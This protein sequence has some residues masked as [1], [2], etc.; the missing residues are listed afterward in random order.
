M[1]YDNTSFYGD[2]ITDEYD[3]HN[4]F[5]NP[6]SSTGFYVYHILGDSFDKMSDMCSQFLNDFSILSADTRGLD[7]F[8]GV[9]YNLERPTLPSGR[10]LND[11]EYRIYLYLRNC[12]LITMQDIEVNFSKCFKLDD[13]DVYFTEESDFLAT[14]DHLNYESEITTSSNLKKQDDDDEGHMI[15][16]FDEDEDTKLIESL[17]SDSAELFTVINVPY[18][19]WDSEFL[20]YLEQFISIKGNLKIREYNL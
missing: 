11:D 7:N 12:R 1:A 6:P 20:A 2:M 8:W 4:N 16:N 19:E 9:S 15:T 3:D 5:M 13:Y 14:V 10:L 17:L 18:N